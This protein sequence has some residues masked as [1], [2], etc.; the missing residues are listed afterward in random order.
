VSGRAEYNRRY[1]LT[2]REERIADA[3]RYYE[4]NRDAVNERRR[5]ARAAD[6]E[7]YRAKEREQRRR[8]AGLT[9]PG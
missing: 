1:Y 9:S 5:R 3:K 8:R 7:K 4:E 6:P 2:N